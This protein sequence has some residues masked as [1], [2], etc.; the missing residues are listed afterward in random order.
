MAEGKGTP[1]ADFVKN[2][3]A[4]STARFHMPGHKGAS[5]LGCERE[6][7]TEIPG[8]DSLYE[9]GGVIRR[10][11]ERASRLFGTGDTLFSA[12][13]SSQ[14][15]RAMVYL[16]CLSGR[17]KGSRPVFIAARNAHKAFISAAA[18]MDIDVEW[19]WPESPES[20]ICGCRFGTG[21]LESVLER[22][23]DA[24]AV[25]ITSPDYLGGCQDIPAI[26]AA[27]HRR[28][29]PLLVDNAHGAYMAF[30]AQ[31]RHPIRDG[32][33]MCCDSA[34]KTLSALTGGAYLHIA[35]SAPEI[36]FKRARQAMELFGSTSPSYLILQSLDLANAVMED[37]FTEKLEL[38]AVRL[39][40]IKSHLEA[41]GWQTAGDEPLKL[42]LK[43]GSMGWS[44]NHLAARLADR[45]VVCEYSDRDHTVFMASP[46]N[47]PED[48]SRLE[49]ALL[50]VERREPI[51]ELLLPITPKRRAMSIREAVMGK[52][53]D[54]AVQDSPGRT[55]AFISASCPPA[56]LPVTPGEIIDREAAE[57]IRY[58]GIERVSVVEKS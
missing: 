16:A 52:A 31:P 4:E 6:D 36:F 23:P 42:T 2:Y 48:F 17:R 29:V 34:H 25:Y 26:A 9:A 49:S 46:F 51:P 55:A 30:L 33:D 11:E 54:T 56:I 35:A 13:G 47:T 19:L 38:A 15:I 20:G 57:L 39:G 21:Q 18:L 43:P 32:A 44:G 8:A 27:A 41:L 1:L 37:G 12:E 7:I 45:G 10:S 50:D 28:G 3:A 58:C 53:I 40:S 22:V 24:A 14:C 5:L